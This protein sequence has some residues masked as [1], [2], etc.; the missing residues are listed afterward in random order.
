MVARRALTPRR[1]PEQLSRDSGGKETVASILAPPRPFLRAVQLDRDIHERGAL[2]ALVLT[3]PLQEGLERLSGGLQ[4]RSPKRAWR[5]TGDYGV[6]KSTLAL[7]FA[8]IVAPDAVAIPAVL[9]AFRNA[10]TPRLLPVLA[11]GRRESLC[12]TLSEAIE[13]AEKSLSMRARRGA[14]RGLY[15]PAIVLERLDGLQ[16]LARDRGNDGV[17]IVID[18]LGRSLETAAE[19]G[20]SQDLILLQDLADHSARSG[21]SPLITLALLHQGFESYASGLANNA[22]REWAKVAGRYDEIVFRND[23][24]TTTHLLAEALGT[25]TEFVP[26]ES[27]QAMQSAA[28]FLV[29]EGWFGRSVGRSTLMARL[30]ALYPLHPAVIPVMTALLRR[31]GQNERS[32]YSWLHGDEGG[33]VARWASKSHVGEFYRLSDAFRYVRANLSHALGALGTRAHWSR[34]LQVVEAGSENANDAAVLESIAILNLVEQDGFFASTDVL[35]VSLDECAVP[36]LRSPNVLRHIFGKPEHG[37]RLWSSQHISLEQA[38]QNA[39]DAVPAVDVIRVV[40]EVLDLSPIVARRHAIETGTLRHYDVQLVRGEH[41]GAYQAGTSDT[42]DGVVLIVAP[43]AQ[44]EVASVENAARQLSSK[45]QELMIGVPRPLQGLDD[46]A[47]AVELWRWIRTHTPELAHD[48]I[49]AEEVTRQLQLAQRTLRLVA[50]RALGLAD[51]GSLVWFSQGHKISLDKSRGLSAALSAICD[52]RFSAA[53]LF[54][55]EL[56][57]RRSL[58]SAAAAAR[59][60]LIDALFEKT[61]APGL[62]LPEETMPPEKSAYLSLV[63]QSGLHAKRKNGRWTLEIPAPENDPCRVRPLFAGLFGVLENAVDRRVSVPR[64]WDALRSPPIGARDGVLP[65]M[66][67]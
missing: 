51:P 62:G 10:E 47:R 45:H 44:R 64:L 38:L 32:L 8:R 37:Y 43:A 14:V 9:S 48:E 1:G 23:V 33:S 13:R 3:T 18:E 7:A 27:R 16:K 19:Q 52:A 50:E 66:L 56:L 39:K 21:E 4:K 31:V 67:V 35:H 61:G 2:S 28:E 5:V 42:C 36:A 17:L 57:N 63:A 59:Q 6:G 12:V 46:H 53:P 24:G 11:T 49:A 30:P 25:Q 40:G 58:S 22:R 34:A 65:L 20:F 41:L 54:K 29:T 15:T 55:N 26:R 60:K